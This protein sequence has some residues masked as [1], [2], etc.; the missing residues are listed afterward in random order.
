MLKARRE[1]PGEKN[2]FNN[3]IVPRSLFALKFFNSKYDEFNM[4]RLF[5]QREK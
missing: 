5:I 1:H 3:I 2:Y 4:G